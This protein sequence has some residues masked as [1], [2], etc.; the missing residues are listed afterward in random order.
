MANGDGRE[1][2]GSDMDENLAIGHGF[3]SNGKANKHRKETKGN[4]TARESANGGPLRP[5]KHSFVSGQL[6]W[7][8]YARFPWWPALVR[9]TFNPARV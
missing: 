9:I 3:L 5:S 2:S 6:V 7:A 4:A 8:K 1:E